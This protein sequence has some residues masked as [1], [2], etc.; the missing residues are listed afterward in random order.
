[1]WILFNL[2]VEAPCLIWLCFVSVG[3]LLFHYNVLYKCGSQEYYAFSLGG[4]VFKFL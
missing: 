4:A 1:M 3:Y 2:S